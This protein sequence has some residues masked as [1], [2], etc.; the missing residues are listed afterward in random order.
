MSA[1]P[2][3]PTASDQL[4][5]ELHDVIYRYGVESDVTVYQA[6]GVLEMVKLD[7]VDMLEKARE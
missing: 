6:I 5:R 4:R 1:E 2:H 3:N 7:L